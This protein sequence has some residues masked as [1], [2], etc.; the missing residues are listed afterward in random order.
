[1][2][3]CA[4]SGSRPASH[5]MTASTANSG[6]VWSHARI[7]SARP[8]EMRN[9]AAS[10]P[11]ATRNADSSMLGKVHSAASAVPPACVTRASSFRNR[12]GVQLTMARDKMKSASLHSFHESHTEPTEVGIPFQTLVHEML[13]QLGEDPTREGLRQTPARVDA[14]LKWLPRGYGMNVGEATGEALC[15]ETPESMICPRGTETHP[16]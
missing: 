16:R 8:C 2:A 3:R 15:E 1:M 10:A 9:C 7:A 4:R 14:S 12:T 5:A 13:E 11:Q 6:S